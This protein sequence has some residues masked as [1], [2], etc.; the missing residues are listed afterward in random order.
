MFSAPFFAV[1]LSLIFFQIKIGLLKGWLCLVL[2]GGVI[3]ILKPP[4]I[5]TKNDTIQGNLTDNDLGTA[6]VDMHHSPSGQYYTGVALALGFAF[7]SALAAI[8]TKRISNELDS[9][10]VMFYTG[11][12]GI[13]TTLLLICVDKGFGHTVEEIKKADAELWM[14][15]MTVSAL[16]IVG[17]LSYVTCLKFISASLVVVITT[18]QVVLSYIFQG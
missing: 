6:L 5:F 15:M 4:F 10:A 14:V 2:F 11:V 17:Y 13:V 8:V 16:G 12:G 7:T 1:L 3:L 9:L 18:M